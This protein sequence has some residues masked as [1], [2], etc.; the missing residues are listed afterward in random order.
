MKRK[1]KIMLDGVIGAEKRFKNV[2]VRGK[3]MILGIDVADGDKAKAIVSHCFENGVL[4]SACGSGGRVIKLIPP[5]TIEDENLEKALT[6]INAAM[7][8]ALEAS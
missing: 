5:L 6:I 1:A 2:Q 4:V 8:S 3:G 7:D